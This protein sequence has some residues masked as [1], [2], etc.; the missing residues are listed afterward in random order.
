MRTYAWWCARSLGGTLALCGLLSV[1]LPKTARAES[2]IEIVAS[3]TEPWQKHKTKRGYSVEK[4]PVRGSPFYEYRASTQIALPPAKLI[5]DMWQTVTTRTGSVVMKRQ[6]LKR[7]ET[8]LLIYDQIK[9]PVVSDR[10]YT[11]R[12][13]KVALGNDR[14]QMIFETAN[15][16]GP[17]PDPHFVRI[18]AIRGCWLIEPS[19]SAK[20]SSHVTYQSYSD[21][22]GSVPSFVIHG[23]QV[24]QLIKNIETLVTR[25]ESARIGSTP[26]PTP[27]PAPPA[28]PT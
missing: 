25:L 27:A 22:G 14:F 21:P 10:D 6:V 3:S 7:A 2:V 26:A 20:E 18:P 1:C 5:E 19:P 28:P 9:T 12:L 4:R 16:L 8:E 13:R 11:L 23:A 17:G 15:E 24:D